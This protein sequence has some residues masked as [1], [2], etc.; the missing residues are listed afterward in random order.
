VNKLL[1]TFESAL[2]FI[3]L[4]GLSACLYYKDSPDA[5]VLAT[6]ITLAAWFSQHIFSWLNQ[7]KFTSLNYTVSVELSFLRQIRFKLKNN[8]E[9]SDEHIS[10]SESATEDS[11]KAYSD[12]Y[13]FG[14]PLPAVAVKNSRKLGFGS[15][16]DW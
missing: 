9:V 14:R 11:D 5:I 1:T 7:S 6:A 16:F 10:I 13:G 15:N 8:Q 4:G 3:V 2:N 12:F